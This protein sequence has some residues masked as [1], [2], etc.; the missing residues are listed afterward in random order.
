MGPCYQSQAVVVVERLR[1]I[2]SKSVPG[3]T[4]RDSPSTSI[5]WIRPEEIAHGS[6]VRHLLNAIKRTNIVQSVDARR[7]PAVQAEDLI[8]DQGSKRQ[9]VKQ[10]CEVFPDIGVAIFPEA[11]VIEAVHLGDLAGFVVPAEDGDTLGVSDLE[12]NK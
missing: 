7:Q 10:I 12:R 1:D 2:L 9:V 5:V 4:R 8:I 11:L 3:A 6:F